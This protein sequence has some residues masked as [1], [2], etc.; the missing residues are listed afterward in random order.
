MAGFGVD[1]DQDRF[2]ATL[3][4]LKRGREF[5]TVRRHHAIV[6]VGSRDHR[7]GIGAA[8]GDVMKRRVSVEKW[9]IFRLGRAAII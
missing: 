4:G 9:K 6:V 2:V 3:G 8:F 5:E 7:R 1:S